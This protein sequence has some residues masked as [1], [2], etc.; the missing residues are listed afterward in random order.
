[1]NKLF[2]HACLF[3]LVITLGIPSLTYAA[4]ED[5]KENFEADLA[6]QV[7]QFSDKVRQVILMQDDANTLYSP[8]SYYLALSALEPGLSGEEQ[9]LIDKVLV[10][11]DMER[12]DYL[13][14]FGDFLKEVR[15]KKDPLFNTETYL[16]ARDDLEWNTSYIEEVE[17]VEAQP[18]AFNFQEASSYEALNEEIA[19]LTEGLIDPYYSQERIEEMAANE[20][21]QLIIMNVLYFKS[22]WQKTFNVE[23]TT[24]ETFYGRDKEANVPMMHKEGE[25]KYLET[26]DLQ[27]IQLPYQNG[28][29]LLIVLPT[30]ELDEEAMWS[31][32]QEVLA[33][34][35]F[36]KHLVDLSLPKWESSS[37]LDLTDTLVE[38]GL[39][40]F[41][42][43]LKQTQFF[44]ESE[45]TAISQ[46][47]QG[48]EFK[49]D[50]EGTQAAA[51]TEMNIETT[52][53]PLV[54][55]P[56]EMNVNRPFLYGIIYEGI[57]LF[58][59]S[60]NTLD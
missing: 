22:N 18:K 9:D 1:M 32:Y 40:A 12:Q 17:A 46:I 7:Q 55:E 24:S 39:E 53:A 26:A 54:E 59:G 31:K 10:P 36:E 41:K 27:A 51:V 33:D 21:L 43:D 23:D 44:T 5:S 50:E 20:Y 57:P 6:T 16:L 60:I 48:I 58:E 3:L 52:S 49:L 14:Q 38:L 28:T 47:L 29:Y 11:K 30:E 15:E 19:E 42:E 37:S 25:Y 13:M 8:F 56:I 35:E 4:E 45:S 2:K 34:G